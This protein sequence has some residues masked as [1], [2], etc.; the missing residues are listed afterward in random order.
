M[1]RT[2][3]ESKR[4]TKDELFCDAARRVNG[5]AFLFKITLSIIERVIMFFEADGAHS[6]YL[7]N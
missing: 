4:A 2:V 1:K 3:H 5:T 7:L 6:E